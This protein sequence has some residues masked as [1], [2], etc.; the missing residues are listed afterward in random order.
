MKVE[1][2]IVIEAICSSSDCSDAVT[3]ANQLY[4][5]VTGDL[6]VAIDNGSVVSSLQQTSSVEKYDFKFSKSNRN[7]TEYCYII[8]N[9]LLKLEVEY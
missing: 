3:V 8:C 9:L 4:E 2:R 5:Q 7:G 1:Y 6:R